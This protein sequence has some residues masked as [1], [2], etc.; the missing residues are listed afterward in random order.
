M[1]KRVY[2]API[3]IRSGTFAKVTGFLSTKGRD[4]VVL[5]KNHPG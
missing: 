4:R 2:E 3:L 1:T 5:S